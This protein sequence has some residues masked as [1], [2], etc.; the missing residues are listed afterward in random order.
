MESLELEDLPGVQGLKALRL[1]V[2][3]ECEALAESASAD[4]DLSDIT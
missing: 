3:L 1:T 4:T 2:N